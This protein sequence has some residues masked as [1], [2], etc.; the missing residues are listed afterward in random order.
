MERRPNSEGT[1]IVNDVVPGSQAEV[2][3][4]KRGDVLCFGGS[5]GQEEMHYDMFLEMAKS[6]QRPLG[7]YTTK[8]YITCIY[9]YIPPLLLSSVD[10]VLILKRMKSLSLNQTPLSFSLSLSL[11]L[12][13]HWCIHLEFEVRRITTTVEKPI[14][15]S[16]KSKSAEAEHRRQAVIAAAEAREKAHKAKSK[17]MKLVTKTTLARQQL[18]Q[19]QNSTASSIDDG[20]R[21]EQAKQAAAAAKQGEAILAQQLGYNPYEPAR[22]TAGQ[23]RNAT[24]TTQH[25]SISADTNS[26]ATTDANADIKSIPPVAPPRD[27]IQ[28]A[29]E[30]HHD[31][32]TEL[33]LPMEFSEPLATMV[34]ATTL[35]LVQSTCG[36]IKKLVINATTKGQTPHDDAAKFRKVR[37]AN[38][39]IKEALVDV[40]GALEVMLAVG[41]VLEEL[42]GESMLMFPADY[43]GPDWLPSALKQLDLVIGCQ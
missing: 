23:A 7:T 36:I 19:Q 32:L 4:M 38:P 1:A 22:A 42:E 3:G 35:E 43:L 27:A 12:C 30:D 20:P 16:A 15:A 34:S 37:L 33:D 31:D 18:L 5:N 2:A 25:G 26:N 10:A 8:Q 40:P 9:R 14:E 41:F 24:T 13:V 21:S 6:P 29:N 11:S 17:P 39:K 28:P